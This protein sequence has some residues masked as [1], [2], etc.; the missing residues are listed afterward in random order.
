MKY[1]IGDHNKGSQFLESCSGLV[2]SASI[3]LS[4]VLVMQIKPNILFLSSLKIGS[5]HGLLKKL[6]FSHPDGRVY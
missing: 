5:R 1:N 2:L 3:L 6:V 4:L